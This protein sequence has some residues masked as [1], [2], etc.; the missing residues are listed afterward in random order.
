MFVLLFLYMNT[1]DILEERIKDS[2]NTLKVAVQEGLEPK[3]DPELENYLEVLENIA[4]KPSYTKD[5]LKINELEEG[6]REVLLSTI[7]ALKKELGS[8]SVHFKEVVHRSPYNIKSFRDN[9]QQGGRNET[10]D[11]T[12]LNKGYLSREGEV[13]DPYSVA[14]S[15]IDSSVDPLV[16]NNQI[17]TLTLNLA[18]KGVRKLDFSAKNTL[19]IYEK[20]ETEVE[21]SPELVLG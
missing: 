20:K 8:R 16:E 11:E 12:P 1:T 2:G 10:L 19:R 3:S 15:M 5:I 17:K 4:K 9:V 7:S 6:D 14:I 18:C 21:P 13:Y